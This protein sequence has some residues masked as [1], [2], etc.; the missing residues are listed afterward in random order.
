MGSGKARYVAENLQ[1]IDFAAL[2]ANLYT[3]R[4]MPLRKSN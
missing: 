1:E 2:A 3:A 4:I